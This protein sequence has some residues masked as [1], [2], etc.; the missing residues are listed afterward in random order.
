MTSYR[1]AASARD[2]AK[3]HDLM[4]AEGLEQ[5]QLS[6]PTLMSW[7]G[8]ELTGF[9]ST[10]I[11]NNA[12]VAGPLVVKGGQ[13]RIWTLMRLIENYERVM[14]E[15]K[16]RSYIFSVDEKQNTWLDKIA[17]VFAVELYTEHK[18]RFWYKR[19]L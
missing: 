14:R 5:A 4:K 7:K 2:Y 6:F 16:I 12:I 15:M 18:G 8:N 3:A 9:M 19:N 1:L 11:S 10:Y 17:E 13:N